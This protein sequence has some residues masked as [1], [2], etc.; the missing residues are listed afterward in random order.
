[1]AANNNTPVTCAQLQDEL[2]TIAAKQAILQTSA[3]RLPK[4][5]A[6][7]KPASQQPTPP[8]PRHEHIRMVDQEESSSA[9]S[10][11]SIQYENCFTLSDQQPG[12]NADTTPLAPLPL[13]R[14]HADKG[15]FVL[16]DL[17]SSDSCHSTQVPFQIDSAASCNTLPSSRLSNMPWAKVLPTKTVILPYASPP[18]KPVGQDTLKASKGSNTC[19]LTFQVINTDQPALLSTEASKAV[20]VLTLNADFIRKC[21]TSTTPLP[22][23]TGPETSQESAAGPAPAPPDTSVRI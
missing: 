22:P 7:R 13:H 9:P 8:D 23:M 17:T 18:I 15:H 5:A 6:A 19:I 4:T 3:D 11:E 14:A 21:S 20:G 12:S 10:E 2:A 1:V 16:L